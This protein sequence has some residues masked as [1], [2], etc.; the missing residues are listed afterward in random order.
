M[1]VSYAPGHCTENHNAYLFVWFSVMVIVWV[2]LH[3]QHSILYCSLVQ[4]KCMVAILPGCYR[5]DCLADIGRTIYRE[6]QS[7]MVV[8]IRTILLYCLAVI[9]KWPAYTG[10]KIIHGSDHYYIAWRHKN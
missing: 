10:G 2:G 6:N 1:H 5:E 3:C 8:T 7:Y 9:E 4:L